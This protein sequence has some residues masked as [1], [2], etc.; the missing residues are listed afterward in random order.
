M[1]PVM[2]IADTPSV[3][4]VLGGQLKGRRVFRDSID[5]AV[6]EIGI[7]C[8]HASRQGRCQDCECERTGGNKS[9]DSVSHGDSPS[10]KERRS[11]KVTP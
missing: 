11:R 7:V 2:V 9:Q 8:A 10:C 4:N 6:A 1:L 3:P 5:R